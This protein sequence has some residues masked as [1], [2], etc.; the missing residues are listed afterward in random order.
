MG[1]A[2]TPILSVRSEALF[3]ALS[4]KA[5]LGA[6]HR[7]GNRFSV[8]PMLPRTARAGGRFEEKSSRSCLS[9]RQIRVAALLAATTLSAAIAG[10]AGIAATPMLPNAD[11]PPKA[12]NL[13]HSPRVKYVA[14]R[15]HCKTSADEA[16]PTNGYS[17]REG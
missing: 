2:A 1:A 8:K 5:S 16:E 3:W 14:V 4:R 6:F 11:L 7:A 12:A 15:Q 10:L 9:R 17:R 13:N